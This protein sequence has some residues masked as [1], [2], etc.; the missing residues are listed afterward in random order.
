M[1]YITRKEGAWHLDIIRI[2]QIIRADRYRSIKVRGCTLERGD[3][4]WLTLRGTFKGERESEKTEAIQFQG[5][6]AENNRDEFIAKLKEYGAIV[7]P[8]FAHPEEK[9]SDT[10]TT[11][12]QCIKEFY[13]KMS[14][15]RG[16]LPELQLS[17]NGQEFE[18]YRLNLIKNKQLQ[19][20][21]VSA[22]KKRLDSNRLERTKIDITNKYTL[23]MKEDVL[24]IKKG[25]HVICLKP[26]DGT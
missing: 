7:P 19:F 8:Q 15:H 12:S 20:I 16:T 18:H 6:N 17:Q 22:N 2:S 24:E 23:E 5:E 4:G 25:E 13:S 9:R 26:V 10:V 14:E 3:D 1:G 21:S 11:Q